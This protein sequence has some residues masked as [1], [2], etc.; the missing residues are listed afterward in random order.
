LLG[1]AAHLMSPFS[2]EGVNLAL[3]DAADLSDAL[4]SPAG[5]K[6]VTTYEATMVARSIPA[7][8]GA[9][10]GLTVTLSANGV[11]AVLDHYR[12]RVEG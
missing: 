3:A 6:A 5:W 12:E 10:E 2:G 4:A 11:E 7:A 8:E 9:A 1:D